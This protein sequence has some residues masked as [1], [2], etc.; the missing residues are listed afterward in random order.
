LHYY[1]KLFIFIHFA[2]VVQWE[3]TTLP[4]WE[5][6]VQPP[7]PAQLKW[8]RSQEAKA[9]VCKTSI[10]RFN[11]DRRLK[12]IQIFCR[13]G[14]N[15][16]RKGLKIPRALLSVP[17]QVRPSAPTKRDRYITKNFII[18]FL[19]HSFHGIRCSLFRSQ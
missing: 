17:V 2:G 14:G 10:H 1:Q 16:R 18:Q 9:E 19:S 5:S 15:G 3:N 7:S 6:R 8:R 4:R 11:S 12:S 13:G